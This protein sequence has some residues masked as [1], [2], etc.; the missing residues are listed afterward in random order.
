M[1]KQ[2]NYHLLKTENSEKNNI[3]LIHIFED[4]WTYKNE[5]IK[6]NILDSLNLLKH[7]KNIN[8]TIDYITNPNYFLLK[9][10]LSG[11]VK[12]DIFINII[13]NG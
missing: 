2:E 13:K 4:E 12:Y 11:L 5:I 6:S 7:I 8:S 1:N 3:K 9:N 10:N